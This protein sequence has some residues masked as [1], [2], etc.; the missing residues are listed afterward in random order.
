MR[1]SARRIVGLLTLLGLLAGLA[2]AAWAGG[3]KEQIRLNARDQANARGAVLERADLGTATGWT[4]GSKKPDLSSTPPCA[5]FQPKQS[6]L[7]LT[8]AAETDW[9]H[10]GLEVD[11]EAQVLQTA[12]MV[13]LDWQRSMVSPKLLP[14]LRQAFAKEAG[15]TAKVVSVR[16]VPFPHLGTY[17]AL[18]RVLVD[19]T[20]V[21]T[22]VRVRSD[23]ILIGRSRTE[24][25]L[26]VTAPA[27]A[28]AG[29]DPAELQLARLLAG[30]ISA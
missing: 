30:R 8:G 1:P 4:G 2:A 6:D 21:G 11:S 5:G 23:A 14:C 26:T 19:V 27:A 10:P 20:S 9:K 7:V 18:F 12:Q 15:A 13:R 17:T 24:L 25:T 3:G 29:V 22:T 16:K 28:A